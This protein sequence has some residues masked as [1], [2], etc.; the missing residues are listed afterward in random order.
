MHLKKIICRRFSR[1]L[2]KEN[3]KE[4]RGIQ[5]QSGVNPELQNIVEPIL[6]LFWT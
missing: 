2:P 4:S 3:T 5:I 1:K 6:R